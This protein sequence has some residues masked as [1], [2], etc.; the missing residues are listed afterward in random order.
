MADGEPDR[1]AARPPPPPAK[2]RRLKGHEAALTC[3][4]ASRARPGV[5]VSSAEDGRICFFDLRCR[6]LLFSVEAGKG[7]VSSIC[8]KGGNE[9]VVYAALGTEVVGFDVHMA[10]SWKPLETYNYNKDEINQISFSSRST[11]LAAADDSGDVKI[12]DTRQKCLYK[13]LRSVHTSICSS[14]QFLS[15]RTWGAISGGLDSKLA[16]WDFSKGRPY[17]VIDFGRYATRMTET[18]N[19]SNQCFNPAFVH[20]IAVPEE[21]MSIG[22]N[23]IC[24]IARG[25]GIVEVIDIE[26]ELAN[27]SSKAR[28]GFNS[29]SIDK[30]KEN[31]DECQGKRLRLD[32]ASG[33][34]T[35]AVSCV[36][37]ITLQVNW[38]CTTPMDSENLVVCDTSKVMK[39]YTVG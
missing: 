25:D 1:P 4:I 26:S 33:G 24:A 16:M 8:Y 30:A 11:F 34:H 13:T 17:K 36:V 35:A 38:I 5:V 19:S 10:S 9:D 12:I 7:P 22:L 23:K 37:F 6:D 28:K 29:R 32:Y 27:T 39:I 15:W 14:V 31:L 20:S 21:D 3:C 18:G 2:P